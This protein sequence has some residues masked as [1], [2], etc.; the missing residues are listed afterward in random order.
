MFVSSGLNLDVRVPTISRQTLRVECSPFYDLCLQIGRLLVISEIVHS[1][2]LTELTVATCCYSLLLILFWTPPAVACNI[3]SL[4]Y[5]FT[6]KDLDIF[7]TGIS[8]LLLLWYDSPQWH[9]AHCINNQHSWGALHWP[10]MVECW[11]NNGGTLTL[12]LTHMRLILVRI[13]P[14]GPWFIELCAGVHT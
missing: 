11:L 13:F 3:I 8:F 1:A 14:S 2:S 5:M 10:F 9:N 6:H 7:V 12:T 4:L